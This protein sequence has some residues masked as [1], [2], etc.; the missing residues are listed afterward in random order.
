[1]NKL[2]QIAGLM[3]LAGWMFAPA[4]LAQDSEIRWRLNPDDVLQIEM[5]QRTG[6]VSQADQRNRKSTNEMRLWMQWTVQQVNDGQMT[7]SQVINRIQLISRVPTEGG[8]QVTEIDTDDM[9][10][11]NPKALAKRLTRLVE[12]LIGAEVTLE[13]TYRGEIV[14]VEIP[15]ESLT[16][17]REAPSSMQLR[18]VFTQDGLKNLF[19]QAAFLAPE[20]AVKP[21]DSWKSNK[22][23]S[24]EFGTFEQVQTFTMEPGAADADSEREFSLVTELVELEASE[25]GG[26]L[27]SFDSSG[28]FVFD[29]DG[30]YFSRSNVKTSMQTSRQYRE[31]TIESTVTSDVNITVNK[32]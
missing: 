27:V 2:F 12:P 15:D 7:I 23:L 25:S 19:G 20:A 14:S 6:I 3:C 28:S 4:L 9:G 30:G 16:A 21:G 17:L 5:Q 24:N 31:K 13:M 22:K 29:V 32:K 26:K 10:G 11:P 18:N 8:E 1:M